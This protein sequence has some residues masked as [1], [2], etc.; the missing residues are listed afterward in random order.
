MSATKKYSYQRDLTLA[1]VAG[2]CRK[3]LQTESA[4]AGCWIPNWRQN[5]LYDFI[6]Q[7]PVARRN[8]SRWRKPEAICKHTGISRSHAGV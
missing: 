5:T 4:V 8:L 6:N 2:C 7:Y 1:G 3:P